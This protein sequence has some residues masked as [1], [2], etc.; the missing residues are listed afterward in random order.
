MA[1]IR[2]KALFYGLCLFSFGLL[3]LAIV[4]LSMK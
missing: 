1:P 2:H 4:L 3:A